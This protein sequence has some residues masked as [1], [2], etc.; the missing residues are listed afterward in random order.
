MLKTAQQMVIPV[1]SANGHTI[2]RA[3]FGPMAERDA[4]D[5]CARLTERGQT[6]FATM[7][8]R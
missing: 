5:L 8:A 3:R 7:S 2:F 4:R 6:C 1:Q